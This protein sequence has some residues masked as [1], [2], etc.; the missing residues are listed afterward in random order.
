MSTIEFEKADNSRF[1]TCKN[2]RIISNLFL[3][4]YRESDEDKVG[5]FFTMSDKDEEGCISFRRL[6][7]ECRDPSEYIPAMKILGN[8]AHWKMLCDQNWFKPFIEDLRDELKAML[9]S[10]HF[11]RIMDTSAS[12][13]EAVSLQAT[14]FAYDT[15]TKLDGKGAGRPRKVKSR[16]QEAAEDNITEM[17]LKQDFDRIKLVTS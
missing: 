3:E 7:L 6:Y 2:R 4:R 5:P 9:L 11:N 10:E 13:K 1:R 16:E 17:R 8:W 15:L 12:A 14:K